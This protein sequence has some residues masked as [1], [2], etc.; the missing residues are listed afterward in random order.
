[1]SE[2]V[3]I[4]KWLSQL[5][6]LS[7]RQAEVLISEG[8]ITVNGSV[9]TIGQKVNIKTDK[10]KV[11]GKLQKEKAPSL[12]YWVFN[13]PDLTLVSRVSQ[14]DKKTIYESKNLKNMALTL[15]AVGRLDYR[16]EGLLLLSNDGDLQNKLCHP[17]NKISRIYHVLIDKKLSDKELKTCSDSGLVLEDGPVRCK[18]KYLQSQKL[19]QSRGFCYCVTVFEGRNRLVRRMFA[20]LDRR[21][22]RLF[23]VAFGN[24]LLP[25]DLKPGFF[26][27]LSSKQI[28]NLKESVS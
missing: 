1:M 19:G 12:L 27:P 17:K 2:E 20:K 10:I 16:T 18:I 25:L 15:N 26:R 8:R 13:K 4:H 3:R 6:S 7:R 23:R 21:V 5:G 22:I 9:A 28:N 24:I 11:D 14:G